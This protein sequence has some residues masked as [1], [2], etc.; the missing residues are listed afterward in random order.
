[1][2]YRMGVQSVL[3]LHLFVLNQRCPL[4]KALSLIDLAVFLLG[5]AHYQSNRDTFYLTIQLCQT[6]QSVSYE[7]QAPIRV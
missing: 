5:K 3:P 1:M 6:P 4:I 7:D 2:I